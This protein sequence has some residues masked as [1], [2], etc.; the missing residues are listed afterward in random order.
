MSI[1]IMI[2]LLSLL[3]LIHEAGH[4]LA[5]KA[6]G[7]KVEKF[8]FGLP[9]GPTLFEKKIGDTTFLVHALLLGGYVAFPDD[10]KECDLPADSPDRFENRP[11]H[12]R[13]IVVS[14]GVIANILCAFVLVLFAALAWKHLPSGDYNIEV[15]N[16]VAPKDASVWTSG[17]KQGDRILSANGTDISSTYTL[18]NI[19]HLSKTRDGKVNK[20]TVEK[21]YQM[22]KA[23]NPGLG[24]D[25]I[26]PTDIAIRLP[27]NVATEPPII[28]NKKTALG[29]EQYQDNQI[30][31]DKKILKLRN[32]I[33]LHPQNKCFITNG[34]YSIYDI[35][36]AISDNVHPINLVI[37][38]NGQKIA[39]NSIYPSK[40]GTIGVQLDSKEIL[41]PT[42]TIGDSIVGTSK[43]LYENTYMMSVGL[44]QVFTGKVPLKDLHGIVAITKIGGDIIDRD[45]MFYG[46]LLTAIISIDLAIVNF[47]PIPALDGGHVLFL[48]I[49]KLRGKKVSTKVLDIMA[50][51]CFF[52]LIALMLIIVFND[53]F[54]LITQKL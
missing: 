13:A 19:I 41:A 9:L 31:L 12:Q 20:E 29:L 38:R 34:D 45:G 7:I 6:F 26:L 36:M 8:G 27:E 14:A 53:I 40:K 22:I 54:A 42:K 16:I 17:L 10:E 35:A 18:L 23:L 2:L 33:S 43:Y 25:E 50:N 49:E 52:I 4:F 37:K 39:L 28:L 21:N 1:I 47:L 48:I 44:V 51:I 5:A 30:K 32:F 3:V 15:G 11:I 24:K 46:I